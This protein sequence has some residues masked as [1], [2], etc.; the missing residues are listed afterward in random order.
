MSEL[1][2]LKGLDKLGTD[3]NFLFFDHQRSKLTNNKLAISKDYKK[4]FA[5]ENRNK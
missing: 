2:S 1:V 5:A 3:G 4:R